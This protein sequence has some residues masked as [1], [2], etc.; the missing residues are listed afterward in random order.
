MKRI[1]IL[2]ILLS[3]FLVSACA[4]SKWVQTPISK[5][6]YVNVVLE[7]PQANATVSLHLYKH[8][9][10]IDTADLKKLLGDLTYV[11]KAGLMKTEE[12]ISVF[13]EVEIDRLAPVLREALAKAGDRQRVRFISFNQAQS[14]LFSLSRKT[15]GIL[16]VETD[17]QLNIAFNF[18]NSDRHTSETTAVNPVYS[19]VDPLKIQTSDTPISVPS[20]AARHTFE[21]GV[22]APMWVVVDCSKL[23]EVMTVPLGKKPEKDSTAIE[24]KAGSPDITAKR[25]VPMQASTEG[26]KEDIKNKLRYLKELLDEG[27]ISE[28]DYTTKKMELLDKIN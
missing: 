15:E 23:R 11:A 18:I 8:P 1:A 5:Q 6:N 22:P 7:Q 16:F 2:L 20:Y 27:L 14:F 13:Q 3:T 25:A 12:E 9:Y 10:E 26:L 19:K 21:Q 17:G 24:G 4:S 28:E